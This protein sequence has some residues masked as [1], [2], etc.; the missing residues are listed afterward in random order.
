M[1][2]DAQEVYYRNTLVKDKGEPQKG[3]R[4]GDHSARLTLVKE[5]GRKE[6]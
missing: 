6:N 2:L 3:G 5:R 4:P 1:G